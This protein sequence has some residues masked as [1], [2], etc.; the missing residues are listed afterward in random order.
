MTCWRTLREVGAQLDQ[1][2]GRHALA[3][4][5]EAEEDV[6]RTDVVVAQLERLAQ[7]ELED[8]LGSRGERNVP[9]GRAGCH[10]R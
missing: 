2:L 5:D 6:L 8:L 10:G 4:P 9:A 7:R 1:D 3:L